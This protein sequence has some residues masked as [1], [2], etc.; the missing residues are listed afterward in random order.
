MATVQK[1][2][3]VP[4]EMS[5]SLL[6]EAQQQDGPAGY[7]YRWLMREYCRC[8]FEQRQG[9]AWTSHRREVDDIVRELQVADAAE[10]AAEAV[11]Q[12][13]RRRKEEEEARE[14]SRRQE[15]DRVEA[16]RRTVAV[17]DPWWPIPSWEIPAG[18]RF[19]TPQ[20]NQ[21]QIVEVSY[22]TFGRAEAGTIDPYM[23]V[24]DRSD[25]SYRVYRRKGNEK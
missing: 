14:R 20:R 1:N 4:V 13:E 19:D 24:H 17:D 5:W 7:V 25:G 11:E 21:G 12:T 8:E 2:D 16:E 22:G 10:A 6:H 15:M 23:S 9:R 3:D 18:I